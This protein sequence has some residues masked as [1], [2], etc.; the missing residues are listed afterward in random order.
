MSTSTVAARLV[1]VSSAVAAAGFAP[2]AV[3]Y[4]GPGAGLGVLGAALAVLAAIVVTVIGV[5]VWPVRM[6]MRRRKQRADEA[7]ARTRDE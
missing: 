1:V 6:L 2:V 5:V 3:A 4:V 7:A